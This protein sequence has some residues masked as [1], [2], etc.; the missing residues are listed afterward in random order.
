MDKRDVT[1]SSDDDFGSGIG[2][3]R[4]KSIELSGV[5]YASACTPCEI[6]TYS[7]VEGASSCAPCLRDTYSDRT[8]SVGCS[9]CDPNTQYA[10]I[11]SSDCIDKPMCGPNDYYATSSS[12]DDR[13]RESEISYHW[14]QPKICREGPT[15][16]PSSHHQTCNSTL[17]NR[18][19]CSPGLELVNGKCRFC[20]DNKF[21][22]GSSE[23]CMACPTSTS[24][25]YELVMNSWNAS[26]LDESSSIGPLLAMQ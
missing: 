1:S 2:I 7:S 24:P 23:S 9:Q 4:I 16:I 20:S 6:G 12:C 11:R 19:S 21:N 17:T 26:E 10:P 14:I 15:G 8:G 5:A 13:T 3:I 25:H 22:D 18:G